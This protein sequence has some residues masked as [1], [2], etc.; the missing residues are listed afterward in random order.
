MMI[1]FHLPGPQ[2]AWGIF[3]IVITLSATN[4]NKGRF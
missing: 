4:L 1:D 2:V 3:Y